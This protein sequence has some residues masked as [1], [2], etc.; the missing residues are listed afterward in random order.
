MDIFD[1]S[2]VRV[3]MTGKKYFRFQDISAYKQISGQCVKEM[4]VC[5]LDNNQL[6]LLELKDYKQ[7]LLEAKQNNII[8]KQFVKFVCNNIECKLWDSLLMLSACWLPT[9]SGGKLR[10][11]LDS[12]FHQ[13]PDQ[14][15][16]VIVI[17]MQE[18]DIRRHFTPLQKEL[19]KRLKGKLSLFDVSD[20]FLTICMPQHLKTYNPLKDCIQ[21]AQ[22]T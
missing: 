2:G 5:W 20:Q 1:E 18:I 12:V 6:I 14:I 3:D 22:D 7:S 19:K 9:K 11:E 13:L 15:R 4:D 8:P 21:P 17:D 10:N 16:V